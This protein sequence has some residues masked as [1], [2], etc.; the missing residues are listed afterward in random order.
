[1]FVKNVVLLLGDLNPQQQYCTSNCVLEKPI[2][3]WIIMILPTFDA[4]WCLIT[5]FTTALD[6]YLS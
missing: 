6:L 4:T 1:M 3:S 2:I 5:M